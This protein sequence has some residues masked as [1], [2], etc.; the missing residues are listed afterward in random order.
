MWQAGGSA[1][2]FRRKRFGVRLCWE[3]E[4]PKGPKMSGQ[5]LEVG[6][7]APDVNVPADIALVEAA[8]MEL[9]EL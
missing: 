8:L 7:A 5:V 3:L 1:R 6:Y 4:E 9:M 2:P